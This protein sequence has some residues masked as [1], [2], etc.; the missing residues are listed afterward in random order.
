MWNGVAAGSSQGATFLT[1]ILVANLLGREVFGQ[2]SII[3]STL[4]TVVGIAQVATGLTATRY[5]AELRSKDPD[6]AGRILGMCS[7]VALVTG[8]GATVL[9][10][11]SADWLTSDVLRVPEAAHGMLIGAA[12]VLF[13]VMNAYQSGALAGLEAYPILAKLGVL[14]GVVQVAASVGFCWYW[15]LDGAV[16]GLAIT[17]ALRWWLYARAIKSEAETFG[18]FVTRRGFRQERSLFFGFA[19]PGAL[20]GVT[21]LPAIWLANA[22]LVR[23]SDGVAEMALFAAANYLR[24]IV[25]FIPNLVNGVGISLINSQLAAADQRSYS[26]V[27]WANLL[28]TSAATIL[29]AVLVGAL[30]PILLGLF[31]REFVL[32]TQVLFVLLVAAVLEGIALG[33]YQIVQSQGRMWLSLLVIALP[34]DLSLAFFAYFLTAQYA[35]VGLAYAYTA[36]WFLGLT[37]ISILAYRMAAKHTMIASITVKNGDKL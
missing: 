34:R 13:S 8:V 26:K 25:L 36:A 7:T 16:F 29:G 19:L 2:Y 33:P 22:F 15:G 21:T 17:A 20:S 9:I 1:S 6:R 10:G 28:L 18:I 3:L 32:G 12:V 35:A 37:I 27:F 30:G 23:Q 11:V 31:G 24:I 4:L 5:V 14:T